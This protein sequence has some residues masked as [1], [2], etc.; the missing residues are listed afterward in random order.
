MSYAAATLAQIKVV[1]TK[2]ALV[3][4][5][6]MAYGPIYKQVFDKGISRAGDNYDK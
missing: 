1:A 6:A 4:L 2:A 3:E 5:Q